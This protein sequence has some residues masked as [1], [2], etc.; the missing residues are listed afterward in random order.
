[1]SE[2][3]TIKKSAPVVWCV[4][5]NR[6]KDRCLKVDQMIDKCTDCPWKQL[7]V[8]TV[9]KGEWH[10]GSFILKVFRSKQKAETFK[11]TLRLNGAEYTEVETWEVDPAL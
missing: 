5:C 11:T 4:C 10:E 7:K 6:P 2:P 1:M 9:S 3:H 8:F